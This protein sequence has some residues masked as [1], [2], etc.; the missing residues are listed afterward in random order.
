MAQNLVNDLLIDLGK[1]L[2]DARLLWQVGA[3]V[4]AFVAGTLLARVLRGQL[5][6]RDVQRRVIRLGV[7][8]FAPVLAPLLT[9]GF[10]ALARLVL[11]QWMPV[12]LLQF[13][14]PLVASFALIRFAF[15]VLRRV[16]AREGATGAFLQSAE[17]LVAVLVWMGVALYVTGLWPGLLNLL[18]ETVVPV[19]RHKASL[20]VI[21]QAAASVVVTLMV[22]LWA[23]TA[24]EERLMRMDGMHSSLRAVMARSARAL[25]ILMAVLVSLSLVGIDLTVLSVFGGAFGVGLGL[26]LQKIA[27]SYVSGFVILFE[28]SLAIGDVVTVD[29]FAGQVTQINTRYTVIR[30]GDGIET[31]VPN[32]MLVSGPVQNYSLTD[33]TLRLSTRVTVAYSV[34]VEQVLRLLQQTAAAVP[35]VVSEP[36]PQAL[37]ARFD[38]D[39][40]ELEVGV[41]IADP[42]NGRA[43]VLSDVNRALWKVL[44]E[45]QISVPYPQREVRIIN[46]GA[47]AQPP[48]PKPLR[49]AETL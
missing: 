30:G 48:L 17:K 13:A 18:E 44:Q 28:R 20:L 4:V 10:I 40:F 8:S 14:L 46:A 39:G 42:E 7:E 25:L 26:G 47:P 5:A 21:V 29:K 19:G 24:L 36:A 43:N 15:Y 11:G 1:D 16:F 45:H 31:V 32:D 38:P 34:D 23:G 3:L 33:R 9:L 49:T 27:S 41:W 6:A 2:H 35:R 22:A 12:R 37:L